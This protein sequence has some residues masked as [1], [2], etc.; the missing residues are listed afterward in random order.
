MIK[1][2]ARIENKNDG[3]MTE[4]LRFDDSATNQWNSSE[5]ATTRENRCTS[6]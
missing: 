6:F 4:M 2:A 1:T 3:E 5:F